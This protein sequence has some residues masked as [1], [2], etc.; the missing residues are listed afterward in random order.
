MFRV[1]QL[2]DEGASTGH[3]LGLDTATGVASLALISHGRV[4]DKIDRAVASHSVSIPAIVDELVGNAGLSISELNAIAVGIGPGSYTG[5][6]IGLSYAKGLVLATGCSL[7]GVPSFDSIAI[8]ARESGE[9]APGASICVIFDARRGEVYAALYRVVADRLEKR[10]EESVVALEH[11]ASRITG[12]TLFVGDSCAND[13]A[14]LVGRRGLGVAVL[15][16]GTLDLRGVCVAAIGAARL[17]HGEKDRGES[18]EPLYIRTPDSTFRKT[19]RD[20]AAIATEGLWSSERKKSSGG[21]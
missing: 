14:A 19:T 17:A 9:V 21:I 5:L 13:A 18:L 10:S 6:R 15:E 7:V 2:L 1:E 3:V 4:I 8:A 20:P 12:D 16:T 11:L